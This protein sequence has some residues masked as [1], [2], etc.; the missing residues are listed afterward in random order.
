MGNQHPKD[1]FRYKFGIITP[2]SIM[3]DLGTYKDTA[4][5]QEP[6][7]QFQVVHYDEEYGEGEILKYI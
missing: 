1:V 5:Q 4:Q 6:V 7:I 3:S 2:D